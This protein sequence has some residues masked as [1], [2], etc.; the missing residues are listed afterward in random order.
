MNIAIDRPVWGERVGEGG[1]GEKLKITA[2]YERKK[3]GE[4][5][6]KWANPTISS[7]SRRM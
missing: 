3:L 2:W 6:R 5:K 7:Y 1:E 4:G